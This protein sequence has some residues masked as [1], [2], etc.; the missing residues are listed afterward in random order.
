[1][2]HLNGERFSR[3]QLFDP[4]LTAIDVPVDYN[5]CEDRLL[6]ELTVRANLGFTVNDILDH[7]YGSFR[8]LIPYDRIGLA[9]VENHATILRTRW[10]RSEFPRMYLVPG[11]SMEMKGSSLQ[12]VIENGSPRILNDLEGYVGEHKDPES[13][14]LIVKEGLR[15]TLICPLV[16]IGKPVGFLFFSSAKTGTYQQ[17]HVDRFEKITNQ[18][19]IIVEKGRLLDECYE[20]KLRLKAEIGERIRAEEKLR[21]VNNQLQDAVK[22]LAQIAARDGLTGIANRAWFEQTLEKEWN[23]CLRNGKPLSLILIDVDSFKQYNDVYGHPAGDDCLKLVAESLRCVAR[24]SG[25]LV[26]RYGGDEFVVLL[27]ETT[28]GSAFQLAE[29]LRS[30]VENN[31]PTVSRPR[32]TARVTVSLGL[33]TLKPLQDLDRTM[34]VIN[35]DVALYEAKKSG[36][37][38][39]VVSG[40]SVA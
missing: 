35:A 16:A 36:R 28:L 24:R 2:V 3:G 31:E 13:T 32:V 19:S 22:Q 11:D 15:S 20:S 23:R 37:N 6:H 7:I 26:A 39:I 5:Q 9:L 27:P 12:H 40:A 30:N 34:L 4:D 33:A 21:A 25:D 29:K 1:M 17:A 8:Q 14:R 10:E 18:I 38:R